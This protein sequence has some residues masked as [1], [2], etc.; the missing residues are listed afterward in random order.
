MKN[1]NELRNALMQTVEDV[2]AKKM[3]AHDAMAVS[4]NAQAI[5]NLTR[6]ELDYTIL[7]KEQE[8]ESL[9]FFDKELPEPNDKILIEGKKV[10]N[11]A[12]SIQTSNI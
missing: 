7:K 4:K 2:R 3:T 1:L 8:E 12:K 9:D 11:G 5:I 10:L 6:L